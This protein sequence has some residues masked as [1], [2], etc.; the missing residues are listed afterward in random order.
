MKFR[1]N[2]FKLSLIFN[3]LCLLGLR[4]KGISIQHEFY[5]DLQHIYI[6]LIT[7]GLDNIESFIF[8]G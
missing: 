8:P 5:F 1:L 2:S 7:L 6:T 4:D 3:F